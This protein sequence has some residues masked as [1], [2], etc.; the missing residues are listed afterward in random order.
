MVLVQKDGDDW[1]CQVAGE[2]N[3]HDL[4]VGVDIGA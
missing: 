2:R 4:S 3:S 1:G